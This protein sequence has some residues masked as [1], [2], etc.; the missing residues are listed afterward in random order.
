VSQST[1]GT[2][3]VYRETRRTAR[4]EHRCSACHETIASGHSYHHVAIVYEREAE[5]VKRC[6]R[7]QAI[8]LHLREVSRADPYEELWPD[9]RLDCGEEYE[10]H[11]GRKPPPEIAELAFVTQAE[12]QQRVRKQ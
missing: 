5:T 8:H 7:C 11:W 6:E 12:M 1:D 2:Y 3:D 9:E 4:K 10:S